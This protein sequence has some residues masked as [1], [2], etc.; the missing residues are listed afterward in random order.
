MPRFISRRLTERAAI[1]LGLAR[2]FVH[3]WDHIEIP[4]WF[5][6]TQDDID[7]RLANALT[8]IDT[9]RSK[10]RS[11]LPLMSAANL[12][13]DPQIRDLELPIL[14]RIPLFFSDSVLSAIT[15]RHIESAV[16]D[17]YWFDIDYLVSQLG[18]LRFGQGY[19]P[20]RLAWEQRTKD[21]EI[22][23][24][25]QLERAL[26]EERLSIASLAPSLTRVT[27]ELD[28]V[29]AFCDGSVRRRSGSS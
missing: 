14:L 4:D 20:D 12:Q 27:F 21:L 28:V 15:R 29:E 9:A 24:I 7:H 1:V 10:S 17:D 18:L 13:L 26:V 19:S 6:A 22:R 16:L 2:G 3:W 8:L 5:R 11:T 25:D 23:R